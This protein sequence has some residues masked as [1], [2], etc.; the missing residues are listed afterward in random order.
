MKKKVIPFLLFAFLTTNIWATGEDIPF[1]TG[2]VN[3]NAQILTEETRQFLSESLKAHEV[4]TTNQIAILTISTID[5]ENIED[6]A[7]RVFREW[8]LGQKDKNNGILIVIVPN[9]R[10][11][12]IEVGYGLEATLTD[13]MAGRIIRNIMTPNFKNGNYDKGLKDGTLAVIEI[14]EGSSPEEAAGMEN[15]DNSSSGN[16]LSALDDTGLSI[17]ERILIGAFIFGII[18][19]FTILGIV[20]P[21]FG[22]F[23]YIFL[24]PFWAMFPI[25]VVGTKGAFVIFIIYLIVFPVAKLILKNAQWYQN[26]KN[27]LR[28]KGKASIGGFVFSSGGSGGSWSSGSSSSGSSSFSGGGGSSGGGGASGS[29]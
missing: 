9:D 19:I 3:D 4:R 22:W 21:G 25:I 18:G 24:I 17:M 15:E 16:G 12:R 27:D 20:T 6:Y 10:K 26:A 5:G 8:K 14:L 13:L 29:W 7:F 1:L 23:L 28:T 2:R 11:M